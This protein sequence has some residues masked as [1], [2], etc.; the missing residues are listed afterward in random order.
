MKMP[1]VRE[2]ESSLFCRKKLHFEYQDIIQSPKIVLEWRLCLTFNNNE[3]W[4]YIRN[5]VQYDEL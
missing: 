3:I 2:Y 4:K 1:P 5:I